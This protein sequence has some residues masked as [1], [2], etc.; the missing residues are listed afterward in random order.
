MEPDLIEDPTGQQVAEVERGLG[1]YDLQF[2]PGRANVAIKGVLV[3]S[4]RVV[5]GLYGEMFWR[6]MH[7]RLLWVHPE[8]RKRG[9]GRR[10]IAWAEQRSR[11]L[12]CYSV[13]VE[14]MSFQAPGFYAAL[15]Y[16]QIGL[17]QGYEGNACRH[18]FE[19]ELTDG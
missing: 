2:L 5:A 17:S 8:R 11:D 14:T 15:G 4:D 7:V 18:Y 19:K 3:E 1:E 13:T 10:M 12:G 9:L 6:K 16:R